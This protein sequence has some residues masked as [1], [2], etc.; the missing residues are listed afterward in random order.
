[1]TQDQVAEELRKSGRHADDYE[2][3]FIDW[4]TKWLLPP[5]ATRSRGRAGG[6]I[7][8]WDEGDIVD[9]T[10]TVFDLLASHHS[11]DA[12][13]VSTWLMAF[14][15]PAP[16][17][18]V[19]DAWL[20][21]LEKEVERFERRKKRY[22][23]DDVHHAVAAQYAT[24]LAKRFGVARSSAIEM[25]AE[26][27]SIVFATTNAD[28]T[29]T[30]E[31]FRDLLKDWA[32]KWFGRPEL[33][34][35]IRELPAVSSLVAWIS[36]CLTRDALR[37]SLSRPCAEVEY[38]YGQWL[39]I[40]GAL[41]NHWRVIRAAAGDQPPRV[42][43]LT[44]GLT[45]ERQFDAMAGRYVVPSLVWANARNYASK[46]D[47]T[48]GAIKRAYA[49]DAF[50]AIIPEY[51]ATRPINVEGQTVLFTALDELRA[52]WG[53]QNVAGFLIL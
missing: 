44:E 12:A 53:P 8:W 29:S 47:Q 34:D 32:G 30:E 24:A 40:L 41:H 3:R 27:S 14:S 51:C 42:S 19:R 28:T 4:R 46:A 5:L 21:S 1:M 45:P 31:I 33:A 17:P 20:R 13:L 11:A 49:D 35:K 7:Y 18:A 37:E 9:R 22:G 15:T 39:S 52:I 43:G 26:I 50:R 38:A 16:T 10:K 23:E 2:R 36:N 6:R 25:I 48:I